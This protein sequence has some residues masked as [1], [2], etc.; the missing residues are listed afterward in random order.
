MSFQL[1]NW[2]GRSVSLALLFISVA[3]FAFTG[4]TL[5]IAVPFVYLFALLLVANWKFVYWILLFTIPFSIVIYLGPLS[6]TIPDEPIM[7]ALLLVFILL[8]IRHRKLFPEWWLRHPLVLIIILQFIWM[9]MAV[10]FSQKLFLSVK[11]SLAKTWFLVAFLVM[12]LFVFQEKKDF[13]KAFI[14]ML[15]PM[16]A[17]ILVVVARH[18]ATGFDFRRIE[19]SIHPLYYNHVEYSTVISMFFPLLLI[20]YML[21]KGKTGKRFLFAGLI[22]FFLFA[23]YFSYARAAMVAVI[24]AV[25]VGVAMRFRLVNFLMPGFYAVMILIVGYMVNNNKYIDYRP[26]FE[27]TYMHHSFSD[28][29]I[30]TFRGQ[31]MSSMERLYRWVAAV[32]MSQDHPMVGVGPNAFYYFYKPYTVTSFRTYV[33]R[34]PEQ[35]TTHNYFLYMLVEQGWPAMILYAIL[36]F[37][38]FAQAQKV[39]FRF[40]DRFYKLCTM[41]LA[42][43]FG[44][45]FINNFFSEL[46]ETH[47]VGCLFFISIALLI[48]LDRK[49]KEEQQQLVATGSQPTP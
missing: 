2:V 25:A 16:V 24:F 19:Q 43:M 30:A 18:A 15:V 46:L 42:M 13:R 5:F 49:S 32:R 35:S 10:V 48:V 33:S 9:L 4:D 8:L 47:K 38:F 1:D 17:T 21:S 31:D 22:L 44:A 12:P 41:G 40:R 39:Y 28:H 23:I 26:D 6:T 7:W 3:L 34:N 14:I 27:R 36:V 29:I 45:G 37:V 11:F 20:A